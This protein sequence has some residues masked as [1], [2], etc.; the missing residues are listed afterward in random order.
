MRNIRNILMVLFVYMVLASCRMP[1]E[2]PIGWFDIN[3]A[4]DEPPGVGV[5]AERG[6][7]ACNPIID[8]LEVYKETHRDYP[9]TLEELVPGLIAE[10]P[11]S[12]PG[13]EIWYE[14]T[15]AGYRLN[16][17][18]TGPGMNICTYSPEAGTEWKC[19]GAY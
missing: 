5:K 15:E 14:K 6:Y 17:T 18:Y 7:A 3:S 4:T 10:V 11:T 12:V 9:T 16:F 1:P 2:G 19:S 8:A 13:A